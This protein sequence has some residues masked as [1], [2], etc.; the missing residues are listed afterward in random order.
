MH[1]LFITIHVQWVNFKVS[2]HLCTVYICEEISILLVLNVSNIGRFSELL[3]EFSS[4]EDNSEVLLESLDPL[5]E[6]PSFSPD[7]YQK[8]PVGG[9]AASQLCTWVQGVHRLHAKLQATL[10][11]LQSRVT[12]MKASLLEYS[13]KLHLQENK[14]I[15]DHKCFLLKLEILTVFLWLTTFDIIIHLYRPT[16]N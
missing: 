4:C 13:D 1:T 3:L 11:P 14:V 12:S 10:R 16:T 8:Q 9:V 5:I 15:I 7:S 6:K 2:S